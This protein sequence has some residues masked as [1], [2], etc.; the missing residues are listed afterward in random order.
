MS[1]EPEDKR[2][3]RKPFVPPPPGRDMVMTVDD[4][5]K[6][7]D[8]TPQQVYEYNKNNKL[9]VH[10]MGKE[11]RYLYSEVMTAF[12]NSD[13]RIK[14]DKSLHKNYTVEELPNCLPI[15]ERY[16]DGKPKQGKPRKKKPE[17][18]PS[19]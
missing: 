5:A 17:G 7:F 8:I 15:A 10:K 4:V 9:I 3:A 1:T 19:S 12:M 11:C 14:D 13:T 2:K 6:L 18:E 16:E